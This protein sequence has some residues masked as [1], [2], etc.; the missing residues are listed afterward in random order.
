MTPYL[1][2]FFAIISWLGRGFNG[3]LPRE[4]LNNISYFKDIEI[5]NEMIVTNLMY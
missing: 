4:P 5:R 2:S 3:F 1:W